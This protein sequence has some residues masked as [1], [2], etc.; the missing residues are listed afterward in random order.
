MTPVS[1]V[2]VLLILGCPAIPTEEGGGPPDRDGDGFDRA[3]D[4]DDDDKLVSP[5]ADELCN[6]IDDNCDGVVDDDATDIPTWYADADGD[7]YG[8]ASA[9]RIEC[10]APTGYVA[11]AQDCN[12]S[13]ASYHPD[14]AETGCSGPDFN[15]NGEFD[16]GD[17]DGDGTL[18]CED[19]D[20]ADPTAHPG[21]HEECDGIDNDC[22]GTIDEGTGQTATFYADVDGDGYGNAASSV[23]ACAAP[24]NYTTT[25]SDCDDTD[26]NVNPGGTEMCNGADDDCDGS[27]DELAVDMVTYYLDADGD[28]YG[29]TAT[30]RQACDVPRGYTS[31][32]GDCDDRASDVYPGAPEYCGST[33]H[34]CDGA[35]NEADSVD[36]SDYY[37][38]ADGDGYAG[39]YAGAACVAPA[40]TSFAAL[41]CDDADSAVS[42]AAE[43]VCNDADDDCDGDV[44]DGLRVPKVYASIQ[45]AIDASS[46]GDHVCVAG[47]AYTEDL[48][49]GSHT[50]SVEGV[51]GSGSTTLTGT[52]TGPVV[53]ISGGAADLR[54]AGFTVTGGDDAYGAGL[55]A[56]SMSG[57]LEDLELS[58]NTCSSSSGCYGV[59]LYTDGATLTDVTVS[60]NVAAP[61]I[62][63]GSAGYVQGV[64]A[65]FGGSVA[66][67]GLT[68]SDN[69]A[70]TSSV[71]SGGDLYVYGAGVIFFGASGTIGELEVTGN[72]VD[73][74]VGSGVYLRVWGA[75]LLSAYGN[76]SFDGVTIQ[77]N[78]VYGYGSS[79]YV[80]GGGA[81][82]YS[83]LSTFDHLDVR[84]NSADAYYVRG[85]GVY[86]EGYSG[87]LS[88]P[89]ITNALIAGNKGSWSVSGTNYGSGGGL[90]LGNYSDPS[91][92]NVDVHGNKLTG[93]YVDG[94]G[95]YFDDYSG[96]AGTNVSVCSNSASYTTDGSGGAMYVYTKTYSYGQDFEYSNFYG[97]SY[98]EF[99]GVNS[100]VGTAGN[101]AVTPGYTLVTGADS[102]T[103]D[104]TLAAGSRLADEGDPTIF[105]TD[106]TRSDIGGYGGAGGGW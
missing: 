30:T 96:A 58:G 54:F 83:E 53:Y 101:I 28:T 16:E 84:G 5:D 26:A 8:D 102:T 34:D 17:G 57:E 20:D 62:A 55:F 94:G 98:S 64:G 85:A 82:L 80:D 71:S 67:D 81:F 106:G 75:G 10:T 60:A 63:S 25:R 39:T 44:D 37:S 66:V 51:D 42:P 100:P 78:L 35:V 32:R 73:D 3:A 15:C 13:S 65:Y 43:D 77:K 38:D 76:A 4:C 95:F 74:A 99:S 11:N 104:F 36:V 1:F 88:E 50:L 103:W 79:T 33:D 31:T 90:Y 21:G 22:N 6:G 14:A 48:Q 92:V 72:Y 89:T 68:V 69:S 52:G 97:N 105:D 46:S 23:E 70:S 41:D 47:G 27:A 19:C 29:D 91:L 12:D 7:G 87:A 86:M 18:A 56:P 93:D 49:F 24:P 2:A 61:I 59:G 45:D 40:G 9:F